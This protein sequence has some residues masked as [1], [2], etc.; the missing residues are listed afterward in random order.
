MGPQFPPMLAQH[1]QT[2]STSNPPYQTIC[3]GKFREL[4]LEMLRSQPSPKL[5]DL[6]PFLSSARAAAKNRYQKSRY[7]YVRRALCQVYG[8]CVEWLKDGIDTNVLL[9]EALQ[10]E[11]AI[12]DNH[13]RAQATADPGQSNAESISDELVNFP[14]RFMCFQDGNFI[15]P[16][17]LFT[18]I[19]QAKVSLKLPEPATL[20][21]PTGANRQYGI[22]KLSDAPSPVHDF[23]DGNLTLAE[24]AAFLPQSIKSWDV[25]DRIIWN[26][27]TSE[28]LALMFNKYRG[29]R[30]EIHPN[31]VYM[32]IR[33]QMR[34]RTD[35]EH[36]YHDWRTWTVN[37]QAKVNRPTGFN[38][39]SVS[40]TGFRR[41]VIF[42]DKPD[43]PA[44][45]IPFRDLANGVAVWPEDD[46]ALDL[47][48]CARWCFYHPEA[49]FFYPSDYQAVLELVGGPLVPDARHSDAAALK[50]LL[51]DT[52][53]SAPRRRAAKGPPYVIVK[54][55]GSSDDFLGKRKRGTTSRETRVKRRKSIAESLTSQGRTTRSTVARSP[56]RT[57]ALLD[58]DR[59]ED[60]D[61][62][63]YQG[64]KRSKKKE[65]GLRRSGRN[66]PNAI[67]YVDLVGTD[68]KIGEEKN[69][70][71]EPE[72]EQYSDCASEGDG[73]DIGNDDISSE[74]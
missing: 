25:G 7:A 51:A 21:E 6:L 3:I 70:Y 35:E 41:P 55:D 50:R 74:A 16:T 4:H 73:P 52:S 57:I 63:A 69:E 49:D 43:I 15:V 66:R 37:A 33:G 61:D 42:K 48:R 24:I 47:A 10:D 36:G 44:V 67:S 60:T 65:Q 59:E 32:M 30:P 8:N 64:P 27:A 45:P 12:L 58:F 5:E 71:E 39:N 20:R 14:L 72:S 2:Y 1:T 28:D 31:S 11:R 53:R 62:D 40:V 46:D 29:L 18:P 19:H 54:S 56:A 17:G 68:I 23:P 26:G 22:G 9:L 34:K 38:E 13:N